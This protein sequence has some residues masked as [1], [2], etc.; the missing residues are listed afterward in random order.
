MGKGLGARGWALV[1]G[2][3]GGGGSPWPR[4]LPLIGQGAFPNHLLPLHT[5]THLQW[6]SGHR[7]SVYNYQDGRRWLWSQMA[8]IKTF[9]ISLKSQNKAFCCPRK[10]TGCVWQMNAVRM[11]RSRI[12]MDKPYM[13]TQTPCAILGFCGPTTPPNFLEER[14][15]VT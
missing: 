15:R 8:V 6:E 1:G 12:V 7:V 14:L 3:K 9:D 2:S 10:G 13:W 11:E 4:G 5:H